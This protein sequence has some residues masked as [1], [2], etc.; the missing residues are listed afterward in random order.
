MSQRTLERGYDDFSL[1][2]GKEAFDTSFVQTIKNSSHLP[3]SLRVGWECTNPGGP[4]TAQ[5]LASG[6]ETVGMP[7]E[8][9][10][11]RVGRCCSVPFWHRIHL[12]LWRL[13]EDP[14]GRCS[15]GRICVG[16][17]SP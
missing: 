15:I 1:Q 3:R 17:A 7:L 12:V 14:L 13:G 4:A 9:R 8:G 2:N 10:P 16:A 6:C 5:V 11:L